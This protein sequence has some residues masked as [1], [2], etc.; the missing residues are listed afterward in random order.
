MPGSIAS[1]ARTTGQCVLGT[2]WMTGWL[3]CGLAIARRRR[4]V[5]NEAKQWHFSVWRLEQG[6][7]LTPCSLELVTALAL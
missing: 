7:A 4:C 3:L 6:L 1:V 2:D 5:S